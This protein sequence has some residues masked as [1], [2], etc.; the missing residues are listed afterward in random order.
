MSPSEVKLNSLISGPHSIGRENMNEM[1]FNEGWQRI[2]NLD[3]ILTFAE[4]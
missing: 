2:M 4:I 3:L 1:S